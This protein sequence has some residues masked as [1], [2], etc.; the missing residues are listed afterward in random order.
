MEWRI[1]VATV[2]VALLAPSVAS[3][4]GPDREI[5]I[6][7]AESQRLTGFTKLDCTR[8]RSGAK[9]LATGKSREGWRIEI[10]VNRFDGFG[11]PYPVTYGLGK[12]SFLI[13]PTRARTPY[14]S[15]LVVPPDVTLPPFGGAVT[16]PGGKRTIGLG[17]VSAFTSGG[18]LD[19]VGIAG[20]AKCNYPKR[21]K[22]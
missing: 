20:K 8:K 19:A 17:F 1:I 12:T 5:G 15:N 4:A 2:A 13:R 14:F 3:A 16:F 21:G 22:G 6:Y 18:G 7:G 9:L 11:K 10:H